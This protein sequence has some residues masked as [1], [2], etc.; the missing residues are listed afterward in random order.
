L[1]VLSF[2]S[3]ADAQETF[4][5]EGPRRSREDDGCIEAST[6]IDLAKLP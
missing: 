3:M 5:R 6:V 2:G 1:L 4:T